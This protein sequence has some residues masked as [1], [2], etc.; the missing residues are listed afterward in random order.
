[1]INKIVIENSNL[2]LVR[3]QFLKNFPKL[4]V[5][6]AE[7]SRIQ[8]VE[9]DAFHN[10]QFLHRVEI[11]YNN[12]TSI[13]PD[14]FWNCPKIAAFNLTGNPDLVVPKDKPFL[15]APQLKWLDL[16]ECNIYKLTYSNFKNVPNLTFLSLAR[17]RLTVLYDNVFEALPNLKVVDVSGNKLKTISLMVFSHMKNPAALYLAGNLWDCNE[18]SMYPVIKC[19]TQFSKDDVRCADGRSWVDISDQSC[20]RF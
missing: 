7:E 9:H 12:L 10:S 17:N 8:E 15:N 4:M 14:L 1:M 3:T 13:N 2:S 19:L 5:Y 6:H 11:I 18:C 20:D 16:R